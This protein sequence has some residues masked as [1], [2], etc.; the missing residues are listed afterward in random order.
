MA[1]ED[2]SVRKFGWREVCLKVISTRDGVASIV[3]DRDTI[4]IMKLCSVLCSSH[5]AFA[6]RLFATMQDGLLV[7]HDPGQKKKCQFLALILK[8]R[9]I[10]T[11]KL[12]A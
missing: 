3:A 11:E 6:S 1:F 12:T 2:A 4:A 9:N 5:D 7:K 8:R 10:I